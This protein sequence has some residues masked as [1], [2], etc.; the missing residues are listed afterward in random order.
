M[1][2]ERLYLAAEVAV[3]LHH[4]D[5]GEKRLIWRQSP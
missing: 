2:D 1:S 4:L 3:R 5:V